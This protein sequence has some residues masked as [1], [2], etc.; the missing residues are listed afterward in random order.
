VRTLAL[1]LG[2]RRIGVAVSDPTGL[3]AS[4]RPLITRTNLAADLD[5]IAQAVATEEAQQVLVGLPYTLEGEVGPQAK[6]T[7]FFVERLR[8]RLAVPVLTW[9]E[10]YTTV[11]AAAAL[12]AQGVRARKQ[13]NRID[14]AAA[15]VLL[16]H[17]L[18]T[19]RASAPPAP[20]RGP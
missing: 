2:S 6:Q 14:S 9:D 20:E 17:Y 13:R 15:A 19:E 3:L 8:E 16:Q 7:L 10:R 4:S 12:R 5:R 1:D 18:D 11:Q